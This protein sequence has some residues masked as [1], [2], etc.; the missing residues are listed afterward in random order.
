MLDKNGL[1]IKGNLTL[2]VGTRFDGFG[3]EQG[4]YIWAHSSHHTYQL[5]SYFGL[6]NQKQILSKCRRRPLRT[7]LTTSLESG[8]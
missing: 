4:A 6:T 7:E 2:A 1:P 3:S 5:L 8:A